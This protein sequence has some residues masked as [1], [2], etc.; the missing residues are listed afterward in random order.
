MLLITPD[1]LKQ[2]EIKA[3]A[4]GYSF[5]EMM[6]T[7]GKQ[8]AEIVHRRWGS[9]PEKKIT[10]LIGGGKNGADTLIALTNLIH[11]GWDVFAVKV[12]TS[13]IPDWSVKDYQDAGG[14]IDNFQNDTH[15]HAHLAKS[16]FIL[17][18]IIGTGFVPPMR[19]DLAETMKSLKKA[20][21]GKTI[22]AVDCPS[23][24]DCKTGRVEENTLSADLTVCM[25]AVKTGLVMFPAYEYVGELCPADIGILRKLHIKN[26][27]EDLIIDK[28]MVAKIL[29][30]R[31]KES[32]KGSYGSALICGGS[33]NY[34]GAPVFSAKA[35]ILTGVGLVKTAVPERIF[36]VTSGQCLDST[37]LVLDDE[38]GVISESAAKVV[39]KELPFRQSFAIGPGIGTEDTTLR[40]FKSIIFN[41]RENEKSKGVGFLPASKLEQS[42]SI[43][44][45]PFVIDAN[46]LRLLATITE[47]EKKADIKMVLTPHPGEMSGLTGLSTEEIQKSR[48]DICRQYAIKWQQVVVLKGA[49]TVVAS[50]S[51]HVAVCPIAT[52]ALAKAGSGDI[53][54]GLLAGFIAQGVDLFDAALASV[55]IHG[56]A[57]LAAA[58]KMGT[59]R[60]VGIKEILGNIPEVI[61]GLE[62]K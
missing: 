4:N 56:K 26:E 50:P 37:W 39:Q 41:N 32:H 23:G 49:L 8:L 17:D 48:I 20:C 43:S 59:E 60:S 18:G 35:A 6:K 54:T 57:G 5:D 45:P 53:L 13:E 55:W 38:N 51:G 62:T 11:L 58:G 2:Y 31:K 40:F 47:W 33:V 7:A 24:V 34:P 25:E 30:A 44:F 3:D 22:I 29:P 46:G 1:K 27:E 28:E 10:G 21:Q 9:Q 52:S 16:Q 42:Q 19:P 15:L 12:S 61:A 36:D 14:K